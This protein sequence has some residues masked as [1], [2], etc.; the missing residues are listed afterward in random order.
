LDDVITDTETV[1]HT[2]FNTSDVKLRLVDL[3]WM[4]EKNPQIS[5]ATLSKLYST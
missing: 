5:P 1:K 2:M 3:V 4:E